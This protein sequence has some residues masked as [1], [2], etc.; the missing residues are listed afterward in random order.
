M[1][2]YINKQEEELSLYSECKRSVCYATLFTAELGESI[3]RIISDQKLGEK[4]K[5]KLER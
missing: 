4:S 3:K 5:I 1:R 2:D